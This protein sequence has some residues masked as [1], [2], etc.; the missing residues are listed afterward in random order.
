MDPLTA[1]LLLANTIAE[2]VKLLIESQP[3]DVREDYAR[4]QWE[5]LKPFWEQ[6]ERLTKGHPFV[7]I[8]RDES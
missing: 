3:L 1:A 7:T 4:K 6:I 5:V 8:T 2:I